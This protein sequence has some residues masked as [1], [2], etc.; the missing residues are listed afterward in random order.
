MVT[1]FWV[2]DTFLS[3]L[4]VDNLKGDGEVGIQTTG[5]M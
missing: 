3:K 1:C 2:G 4:K 5:R